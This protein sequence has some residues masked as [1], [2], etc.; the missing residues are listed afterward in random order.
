M[1]YKYARYGLNDHRKK[2]KSQKIYEMRLFSRIFHQV[3]VH[4]AQGYG[5]ILLPSCTHLNDEPT[6]G[7]HDP[8]SMAR[9]SQYVPQMSQAFNNHIWTQLSL[10]HIIKQIYN[11]HIWQFGG[12]GSMQEKP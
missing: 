6:H 1:F 8:K 3:V 2:P 7:Q 12:Q 4:M 9:M 11:K 5:N 10:G